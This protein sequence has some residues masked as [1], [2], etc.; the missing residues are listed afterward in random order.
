[1]LRRF[2]YFA[3]LTVT[4]LMIGLIATAP[5][6]PGPQGKEKGDKKGKGKEGD[7]IER[8]PERLERLRRQYSDPQPADPERQILLGHSSVYAGK[9]DQI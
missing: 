7:E 6:Q 3:L 2:P 4:G 5:A 1:M 9:A 8:F